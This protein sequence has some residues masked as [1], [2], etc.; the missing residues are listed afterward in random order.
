MSILYIASRRLV[1][2]PPEQRKFGI[3]DVVNTLVTEDELPDYEPGFSNR[4]VLALY[5]SRDG[6]LCIGEMTGIKD[7]PGLYNLTITV[8]RD[9]TLCRLFIL[10]KV[11]GWKGLIRYMMN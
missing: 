5:Y 2:G 8:F 11:S 10:Q 3:K 6:E 9:E 7:R 4:H 1:I